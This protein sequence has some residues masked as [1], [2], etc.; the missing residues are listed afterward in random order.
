MNSEFSYLLP[1]RHKCTQQGTRRTGLCKELIF[2]Y[3]TPAVDYVQKIC[4]WK[5]NNHFPNHS[6]F[7]CAVCFLQKILRLKTCAYWT[8]SYTGIQTLRSLLSLY[9]TNLVRHCSQSESEQYGIPSAYSGST[10][11][12]TAGLCRCCPSSKFRSTSRSSEDSCG[13]ARNP[14]F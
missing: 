9:S 10:H 13:Q 3:T 6:D 4:L 12:S 2:F 14:S 11:T 5:K 8:T 7:A 1:C